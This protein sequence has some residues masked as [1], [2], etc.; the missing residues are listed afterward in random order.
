MADSRPA[1]GAAPRAAA[2][3]VLSAVVDHGRSLDTVLSPILANLSAADRS[4]ASMLARETVRWHRLLYARLEPHLKNKPLQPL[5]RAL[6]EVGVWQLDAS[7]VPPHAAVSA[8]VAATKLLG[9]GRARGLVNAVLRGHQRTPMD[10]STADPGIQYSLPTWLVAA[11][12]ADWSDEMPAVLGALNEAPPLWLRNNARAQSRD[13]LAA[14]LAGRGLTTCLSGMASDAV[15]LDEPVAADELPEL[16]AGAASI[17]DGGAQLA[18][19]LVDPAP[20]DRVLDACAAPGNKT[21]HL[22]ERGA[23][24]VLALDTDAARLTT[25]EDN[26]KRLGLAADT[27]VADA[28]DPERA[29]WDGGVFDRILIDAPCSGTGVIRRHPD[30]KWLRRSSDVQS[31][32]KRQLALLHAL[33]PTLAPG[34]VL[35]YATCSVLRAEGEEIVARFIDEQADTVADPIYAEWGKDEMF[36]RRI[37]VG[38]YGFDGFYYARLK[39]RPV[40]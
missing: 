36:G 23:G 1:T 34:G 26:L 28:T 17:Q 20:T 5:V 30:I 6:L 3:R 37:A 14:Q 25:L 40:A 19:D 39:R 16:A 29:W 38:Q 21:A 4:L 13:E 11:I 12:R 22:L 32:A 8:T 31:A 9:V 10:T 35:V 33:W 2:A 7:R 27:Q 18:A 15:C 24:A